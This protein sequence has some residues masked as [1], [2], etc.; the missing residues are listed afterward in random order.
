MRKDSR[1]QWT[2]NG[3]VAFDKIKSYL[4]NPPVLM[5]LILNKPLILY[6]TVYDSSM[7][8]VL[9]QRDDTGK[10]ENA[11][12]YLSKKF[13][14]YEANYPVIEKICCA[15]AWVVKRLRQY[16]LYHTTWV[17]TQLDPIK[18]LFKKLS[19]SRCL[20]CWQVLLSEYDIVFVSQ[21]LVK[22]DAIAKFLANRESIISRFCSTF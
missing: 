12:Y 18:Y 22:G 8:C 2:E 10:K 11:I 9:V 4:I 17:V 13:T 7:G 6:L 20:A 15:L 16:L 1:G 19:S 5:P 3:Q 21:K 14:T